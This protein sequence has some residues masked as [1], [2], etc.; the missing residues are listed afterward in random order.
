MKKRNILF[1]L[2]VGVILLVVTGIVSY[3]V[4][5]PEQLEPGVD[6]I[7]SM[8][9][10]AREIAFTVLIVFGVSLA[11]LL[12]LLALIKYFRNKKRGAN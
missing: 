11:V 5:R 2:C 10:T 3:F 12:L 8:P 9:L 4:L 7:P 6:S 1:C